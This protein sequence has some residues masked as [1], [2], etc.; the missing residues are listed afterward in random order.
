[1]HLLCR[2]TPIPIALDEELIGVFDKHAKIELLDEIQ[3]QYIILKPSLLGGFRETEN[4]IRLAEPRNIG[5]P[6]SS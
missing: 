1:M 3:P 4:W 5:F 2:K 6:K